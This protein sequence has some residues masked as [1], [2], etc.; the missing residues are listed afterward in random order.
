MRIR[1]LIKHCRREC[2]CCI[3]RG[4]EESLRQALEVFQQAENLYQVAGNRVGEALSLL[5]I[6]S[7]YSN[8]DEKQPALDYFYRALSLFQ[9]LTMQTKE[10]IAISN[11]SKNYEAIALSN[12][13]NIYSESGNDRKA[14]ESFNRALLLFQ[15]VNNQTGEV[16]AL[17]YIGDV[18]SE[19]GSK[20]GALSY[21]EDALLVVR[22]GNDQSGE[23]RTLHNIGSLYSDLGNKQQA[24]SYY[25]RAFQLVQA[26]YGRA[27]DNASLLNSFGKV[28][29]DLG[30]DQQAL[31][32]YKRALALFKARG[33]RSGEAT[34][35]NGIGR[36]YADSGYQ[37]LALDYYK[38][39]LLLFQAVASLS[40]EATV[41]NNIGMAYDALGNEPQA[42]DYFNQALPLRQTVNDPF[43]EAA[44]LNN[45][46]SVYNELGDRQ[47]ALDY[48]S[49]SLRLIQVVGNQFI[50]AT[51]FNNIAHT[52]RDQGK[53]NTALE[54]INTAITIIEELRTKIGGE[55]LR[56]SYF[57]TVQSSYQLKI[58]LL[59]QLGRDEE[60]FETSEAS[61]AR[62][63]LEL[64]SESNID[65][66]QGADPQLLAQEK[67][68][69]QNLQA[70]EARRI[71]TLSK[72]H[73][74]QQAES[75]DA[76][77]NDVFNQLDQTIAQIR[78][79]SPAAADILQP[80]PLNL[81]QIRQQLLDPDTVL[82]QYALGE[83]QSYL[84]AVTKAGIT[85]H[86]LPARAE[87]ETA[88]GTLLAHLKAGRDDDAILQ[89]GGCLRQKILP[90]EIPT[91][92]AG[93]KLIIAA[94]G[95]LQTIPFAALPLPNS[96]APETD[97]CNAET[98]NLD[99]AQ[100]YQ[101][102]I[103]DYE[104]VNIPSITSVQ[105]LRAQQ[106]ASA[107]KKLAILADPIFT[108]DPRTKQQA[109]LVCENTL[110]GE[111]VPSDSLPI[112]LQAALRSTRG[113]L[114]P[115]PCTRNEAE[116]IRTEI[117]DP[118]QMIEA[119]DFD[120]TQDWVTKSPL[121]EYKIVHFATHGIIDDDN[122][123]L[124]GLVMSQ[125]NKQGKPIED[126]YLRLND[127]F[128]LNLNAELVVL[129][130]CETGL[131]EDVR[132]EGIIGLTRGFMYAGAKRVMTSFWRVEDDS[133]AR[134]MQHFY[135]FML[136]DRLSP[137]AA[138]RQ[139]QLEMRKEPTSRAKQW[140]AFT[141]QG[142]WN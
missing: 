105:I 137:S 94:D 8:L 10:T 68:L 53:L 40:G 140:A 115:L 97:A 142:E 36:I 14:L 120:A 28:Y 107:P 116:A 85:P 93:K 6:G 60:A 66:Q 92:A 73:T 46:G 78:T 33:D 25:S 88:A 69:R 95:I 29:D 59:M 119:L 82:L 9:A 138:L 37:Q 51:A 76:E 87:I 81:S 130:A 121:S 27:G 128:N 118:T 11:I 16:I 48:Y 71:Q 139:A 47:K 102:L 12:I 99:Q 106:Q 84:F 52:Y 77:S 57:A 74:I 43:G 54:K 86:V 17:N 110:R 98:F 132:G 22:A 134:L 56:A 38:R 109:Q 30:E 21:Y 65:I 80:K 55:D 61:R 114:N 135:H 18:Y 127:I 42:L 103:V 4:S 75:I 70:I 125:V 123:G 15:S 113:T 49:R 3:R 133:T 72:E 45:I 5:S 62:T 2:G 64:L 63:L 32:Y 13:G 136:K 124:S 58:D 90:Q 89:A 39:A 19:L 67:Q 111:A 1:K 129:S 23:V 41:L 101:P 141:I 83:E 117:N 122:P 31:D 35:L 126:Y 104:I 26:G 79:N 108:T 34:V 96:D 50:E 112:E 20:Q 24:L 100:P 91:M 131:G 7:I 44:T